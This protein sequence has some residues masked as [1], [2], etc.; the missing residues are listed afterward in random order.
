MRGSRP[1]QDAI[2]GEVVER[3]AARVISR[4]NCLRIAW[5]LKAGKTIDGGDRADFIL[6]DKGQTVRSGYPRRTRLRA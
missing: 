2:G 4:P 5:L 3:P 6:H 1:H